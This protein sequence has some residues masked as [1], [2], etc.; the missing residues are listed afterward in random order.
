MKCVDKLVQ[1]Y[2]SLVCP[3]CRSNI[4]REQDYDQGRVQYFKNIKQKLV[5]FEQNLVEFE[6][7]VEQDI[8][9]YYQAGEEVKKFFQYISLVNLTVDREYEQA[10]TDDQIEDVLD[11]FYEI[12]EDLNCFVYRLECLTENIRRNINREIFKELLNRNQDSQE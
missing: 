9:S 4:F 1:Q 5:E 12:G 11:I 8:I 2:K 6:Q 7:I 10:S 3:L